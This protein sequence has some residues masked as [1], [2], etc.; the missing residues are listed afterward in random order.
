LPTFPDVKVLLTSGR[1]DPDKSVGWHFLA[2]PYRLEELERKL[3]NL[4][5]GRPES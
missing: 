2:K 3:R 1:M 4:L 5:V